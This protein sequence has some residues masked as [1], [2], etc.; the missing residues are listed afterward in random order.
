MAFVSL[1]HTCSRSFLDALTPTL[2][3]TTFDRSSLEWFGARLWRPTPKDLP[4]S[5]VQLMHKASVHDG[6]PFSSCACGTLA[7]LP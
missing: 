4:S 5:P 2:T 1:I 7:T 6:P 3:T